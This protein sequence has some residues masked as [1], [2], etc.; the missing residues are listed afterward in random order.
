M[1]LKQIITKHF[2]MKGYIALTLSPWVFIREDL[3]H[4]YSDRVERHET[5]HALQQVE[6][7]WLF[8]LIIYGLEYIIKLPL[9]DF[10]HSK[11]Y[12]SISF[13]QEAYSSE[14]EFFYNDFRKHYTWLKFVFNIKR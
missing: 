7:L 14:N 4:C 13:E 9:C 8:F 10:N 11:A 3:K 1:T 2:P 5:T 12:R 6:C